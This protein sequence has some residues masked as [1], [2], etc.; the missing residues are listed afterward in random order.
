MGA[1][2]LAVGAGGAALAAVLAL[3][4]L[5]QRG[6]TTADARR[7]ALLPVAVPGAV[8][9]AAAASAVTAF[10]PAPP[11]VLRVALV[12][13]E[14]DEAGRWIAGLRVNGGT[15]R[16][17]L[18]GETVSP[19][20]RVERIDARGVDLLRGGRLERL[21]LPA[22]APPPRRAA[23]TRRLAEPS[24]VM[25]PAGQLPPT[26]SAVDRAIERAVLAGR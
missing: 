6:G 22:D 21:A 7:A 15:P 2:G 14:A 26:T 19:G 18:Q 24:V 8:V 3:V 5:S 4:F 12:S 10:Q 17:A 1:R 11:A 20:V 16:R 9:P 25:V 23:P 13:V